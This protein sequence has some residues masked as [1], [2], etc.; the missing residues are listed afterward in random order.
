M[1]RSRVQVF[2]SGR[3]QGVGFRHQTRQV[4]A[5]FGVAGFVRNL[6]DQRVEVVAEGERS[7]LEAFCLAVRDGLL[8]PFIRDEKRV[9]SEPRD[10]YS[11]FEIT[12]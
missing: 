6:P 7:E 10:E 1:N 11:G 5:R 9:W 2:Y 4:A 8:K 12:Q 3:V